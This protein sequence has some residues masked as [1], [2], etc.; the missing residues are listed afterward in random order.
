MA[1]IGIIGL[2]LYDFFTSKPEV[3]DKIENYTE[4]M[5]F[6]YDDTDTKWN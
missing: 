4:Y 1:S 6:S 3:Y 5:S 2:M